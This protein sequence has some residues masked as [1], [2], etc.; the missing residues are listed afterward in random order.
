MKK[1]GPG[2]AVLLLV[3]IFLMIL[4]T[5]GLA[6][7]YIFGME[8]LASRTELINSRAYYQADGGIDMMKGWLVN[9]QEFPEW[10]VHGN[11]RGAWSPFAPQTITYP[12]AGGMTAQIA[13]QIVPSQNPNVSTVKPRDFGFSSYGYYCISSSGIM[14]VGVNPGSTF[15]TTKNITEIVCVSSAAASVW[16]TIGSSFTYRVIQNSYY[17]RPVKRII[18]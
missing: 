6:V 5:V 14:T 7:I 2:G 4:T 11:G 10:D 15:V 8:A 3:L 17:E 12:G 16:S 9:A 13:V 18:Q 1:K